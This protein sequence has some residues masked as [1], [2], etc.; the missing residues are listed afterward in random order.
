MGLSHPH[1]AGRIHLIIRLCGISALVKNLV[2]LFVKINGV[3]FGNL[4]GRAEALDQIQA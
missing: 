4:Q 1:G 2:D 3:A